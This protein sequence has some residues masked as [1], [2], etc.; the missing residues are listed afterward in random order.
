MAKS[1]EEL[2]TWQRAVQLD[3]AVSAIIEQPGFQKDRRLKEQILDAVD[4]LV[5]TSAEGFEQPTDR[6]FAKYL[7]TSKASN[8]ET[9]TRWLLAR[10]RRYITA[11]EFDTCNRLSDELARMLSGFIKYLIRSDRRDRGLGKP[12]DSRNDSR[13]TTDWRLAT[14]TGDCDW[15]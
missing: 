7:Y 3:V 8:G 12:N 2:Q 14:V 9:R 4:S 1:V 6:A 15:D 5:S 11:A 10:N 13:L